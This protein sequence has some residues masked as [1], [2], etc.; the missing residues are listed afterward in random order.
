LEVRAEPVQRRR[1]DR[2]PRQPVLDDLVLRRHRAEL[3]AKL[4]ELLDGEAAV[5]R[6]HH[7]LHPIEPRFQILDRRDLFL[8]RHPYTAF[9]NRLATAA[10]STG[11]PGPIVVDTVSD[12]RYVPFAAAGFA[13]TIASMSAIAFA[14][15]CCSLNEC[16][17][18][19]VRTLPAWPTR[20]SA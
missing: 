16:L 5:L 15:S 3:L 6:E 10:A 13:R 18:L 11:T 17:P 19:G 12:R 20:D 14:A 8:R 7:G 1:R 4:A 9:L 2:Q